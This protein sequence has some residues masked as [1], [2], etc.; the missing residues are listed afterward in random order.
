[1]CIR[2]RP[3]VLVSFVFLRKKDISLY[4]LFSR[5]STREMVLA[6]ISERS[7]SAPL[8]RRPSAPLLSP[9][10]S[11][12]HFSFEIR[13]FCKESRELSWEFHWSFTSLCLACLLRH[14]SGSYSSSTVT[15]HLFCEPRYELTSP[16][17]SACFRSTLICSIWRFRASSRMMALVRPWWFCILIWVLC[18]SSVSSKCAASLLLI[19][20][21]SQQLLLFLL[22]RCGL[23]KHFEEMVGD[24]IPNTKPVTSWCCSVNSSTWTEDSSRFYFCSR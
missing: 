22:S 19:N 23:E 20:R 17:P 6:Q 4:S 13:V 8:Y 16:H 14:D 10:T 7:R 18:F 2:D 12:L 1:M 11:D 24:D 21:T 3:H 9:G 15:L 5:T